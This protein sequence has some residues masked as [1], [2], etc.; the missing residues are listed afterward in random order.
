MNGSDAELLEDEWYIVRHSG[1]TPEIAL[2]SALYYLTRSKDGPR[3][4]LSEEQVAWLRQAA[5]DRFHEIIVRDLQ[6][7]NYGTPVSRGI[8]RSIVNYRRFRTFCER[9]K[10]DRSAVQRQ[11]AAAL[12]NFLEIE[13]AEVGRGQRLPLIDC[14]YEELKCFAADLGIELDAR[15]AELAEHCAGTE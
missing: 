3:I 4:T 5:V 15:F 12:L 10:I 6:H 8:N 13:I 1:E 11:T 2:H 7:A 9:Q 14:P